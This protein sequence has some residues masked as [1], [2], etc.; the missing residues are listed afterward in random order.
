MAA[1]QSAASSGVAAASS[2]TS[3]VGGFTKKRR[4][5]ASCVMDCTV[6]SCTRAT[7][8]STR[9]MAPLHRNRQQYGC[10]MAP[11][12]CFHLNS[13]SPLER[14]TCSAP[15]STTPHDRSSPCTCAYALLNCRTT[16]VRPSARA[17]SS[18]VTPSRFRRVRSAPLASS[19]CTHAVEP[20]MAAKC[21]GV[22]PVCMDLWV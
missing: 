17:T 11:C 6:A 7:D 5:L 14:F 18:A 13:A 8:D 16:A 20:I 22:H 1:T 21:S 15:S 9:S 3:P 10:E 12:F 4:D 19:T 2:N